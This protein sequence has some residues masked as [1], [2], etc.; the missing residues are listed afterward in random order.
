M[1]SGKNDLYIKQHQLSRLKKLLQS[2]K[3][4]VIYGPRRT[5]KTTLIKRFLQDIQEPY[6]LVNGEDITVQEFL[7]SQSI[8]KLKEFV[9]SKKLLVIDEA[10]KIS[11][12][13]INLKLLVDSIPGIKIIAT[14]SSSFE[15]AEQIGEPLVGRKF[16]VPMYPLAQLELQ[17]IENMHETKSRLGQ[18]LVY[19]SYPEI[20]LNES[21]DFRRDYLRDT[22]NSYLLKDL[23]ELEDIRHRKKIFDLL[24]LIAFQIGSEVSLSELG[25]QLSLSQKT[26]ER[27]LYLL[28]LAF[29]VIRVGGFSRNLRKEITKTARYYF[30]DNGIRNSI[31]NNFNSLNT[32]DDIGKL[33]ENYLFM[34]R[35]KKREY[36]GIFS[37][38]YFW[39][40]YTKQEIDLVEDREGK[41]FGYEFTWSS[42]KKKKI[43]SEWHKAYPKASFEV[44]DPDNYLEFI[45]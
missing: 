23:F 14:G 11:K 10:Q 31:I 12:I 38:V 42:R 16:E 13:G 24:Q 8:A 29:V 25:T 33:W 1:D 30:Y 6:L 43:P 28:E 9:G 41:L 39:R 35:F 32:R 5:G 36:Q 20:I 15:L 3:V 19:G 26:V 7:S 34:E 44:I 37:N 21:Q 2:N 27:Y 18:R 4:L 22:V 17:N 45:I 40:T